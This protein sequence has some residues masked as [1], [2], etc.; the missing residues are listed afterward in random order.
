MTIDKNA[1]A[2]I[3]DGIIRARRFESVEGPVTVP[4]IGQ[5]T[6]ERI[7]EQG[8]TVGPVTVRPSSQVRVRSLISAPVAWFPQAAE[9]P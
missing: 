1:P 3:A 6:L 2:G 8:L 9:A 7:K 5:R 4:G